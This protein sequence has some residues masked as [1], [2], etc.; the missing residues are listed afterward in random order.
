MEGAEGGLRPT[1]ARSGDKLFLPRLASPAG[2]R[3]GSGHAWGPRAS[4]IRR[5]PRISC[6][7]PGEGGV[8]LAWPP[9]RALRPQIPERINPGWSGRARLSG[10][11]RPPAALPPG[12]KPPAR[13]PASPAPACRPPPP[14]AARMRPGG[15]CPSPQLPGG[16]V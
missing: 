14:R 4:D 13:S 15:D 11:A 8:S 16:D 5:G 12:F 10:A 9:P 3:C 2:L 7:R 6:S 1:L